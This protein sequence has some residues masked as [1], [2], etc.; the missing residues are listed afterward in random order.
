MTPRKRVHPP[1]SNRVVERE[2][3]ELGA[4]LEAMEEVQRREP[5]VGDINDAKSEEV[6]VKEAAGEN[7]AKK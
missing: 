2:T 5:D 6:E 3:R 4:R 7:V 1:L